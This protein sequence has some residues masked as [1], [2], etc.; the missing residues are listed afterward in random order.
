MAISRHDDLHE[1]TAEAYYELFT[2]GHGFVHVLDEPLLDHPVKA[3][4][5]R[6]W[7]LAAGIWAVA[8]CAL[9]ALGVVL[10]LS[11]V[12]PAERPVAPEQQRLG[13]PL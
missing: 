4:S 1:S 6:L 9:V 13:T 10:A 8:A 11:Y 5:K 3:R 7:K 12:S 2:V